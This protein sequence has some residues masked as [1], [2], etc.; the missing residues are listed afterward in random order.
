MEDEVLFIVPHLAYL[1]M[2]MLQLGEV[3][4]AAVAPR[5]YSA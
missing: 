2:N 5:S 4:K 3:Y 1:D